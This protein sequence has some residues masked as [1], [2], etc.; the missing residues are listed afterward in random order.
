MGFE[1]DFLPVG[2]GERS[3]DAI[4]LR[5]RS[6]N[7]YKIHVIDGGDL[8]AGELMVEHI[9]NYYG[10]P[11]RIDA[12]ICTHGDKDHCSGLRKIIEN[13]QIGGIWM[14]R[15]WKYVNDLIQ[16]ISD[17]RITPDS[18]DRRLREKFSVLNEIEK[19]ADDHNIQLH[20]AF[21]GTWIG[22]FM[23]LA[24]SKERYLHLIP[25]FLGL[26][27]SENL[28]LS[29][30]NGSEHRTQNFVEESFDN[31]TLK[32]NVTT[33]PSNESSI[34]QISQLVGLR[35]LLTGDA[36]V[37]SLNEATNY[38]KTLIGLIPNLNL[39]QIPHHGS[40]HNISPSILNQW[41]GE[42]G[43]YSNTCAIASVAQNANT[44]PRPQVVNALIRRGCNVF[45]T[46][47]SSLNYSVQMPSRQYWIPAM[48]LQFME[49][50][51]E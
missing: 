5:Y 39:M 45:S 25:Q 18:F 37:Q 11:S 41:L 8:E 36:G 10:N 44:H 12:V 35:I 32:E 14:N 50:F 33:S 31:E 27:L 20:E 23:I 51:P 28:K 15:P 43:N 16:Y 3:G 40:R 30:Y 47:G 13:F 42:I 48:P 26:N 38:I 17:Q 19:I 9:R 1:V 24:P 21:Q 2:T 6:G 46:H 7:N 49:V 29:K 22:P 34:V 4:A